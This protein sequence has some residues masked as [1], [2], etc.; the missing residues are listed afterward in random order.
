MINI[1]QKLQQILTTNDGNEITA[2]NHSKMTKKDLNTF[3]KC[4]KK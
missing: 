4:M 3:S 1:N 2:L